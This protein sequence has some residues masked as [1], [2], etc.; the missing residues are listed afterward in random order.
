MAPSS[1][2]TSGRSIPAASFMGSG[3]SLRSWSNYGRGPA[4][5][6]SEG[7]WAKTSILCSTNP[8]RER[9]LLS[10]GLLLAPQEVQE[11][12]R[13]HLVISERRVQAMRRNAQALE[14]GPR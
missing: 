2:P 8:C 4:C 1:A 14:W 9:T 7:L 6:A 11:G 10:L 12:D 13:R 5:E 3:A